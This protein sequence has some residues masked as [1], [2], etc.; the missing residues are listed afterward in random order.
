[1][2]EHDCVES[3]GEYYIPY[4]S[5]MVKCKKCGNEYVYTV[6][7]NKEYSCPFCGSKMK[8]RVYLV[9]STCMVRE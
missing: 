9:I 1:M 2:V 6:E 4:L 7:P 3:A 5:L 8:T